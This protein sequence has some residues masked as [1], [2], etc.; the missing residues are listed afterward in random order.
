MVYGIIHVEAV[1][2]VLLDV[3]VLLTSVV[4]VYGRTEQAV[5]TEQ[6]VVKHDVVLDR[7][8]GDTV[9]HVARHSVA[10]SVCEH[11]DEEE[12]ADDS[13]SDVE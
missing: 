10:V 12:V 7:P 8:D 4:V 13:G 1:D 5:V 3:V 6:V 11:E 2:D 9:I